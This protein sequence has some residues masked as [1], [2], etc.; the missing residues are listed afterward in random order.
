MGGE[1]GKNKNKWTQSA[2]GRQAWGLQVQK[3]GPCCIAEYLL[4]VDTGQ[5][6]ASEWLGGLW[7]TQGSDFESLVHMS[8]LVFLVPHLNLTSEYHL[9]VYRHCLSQ[10]PLLETLP[11]ILTGLLNPSRPGA[12][13]PHLVP[14]ILRFCGLL[15]LL[16]T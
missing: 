9:E 8:G 12:T 7:R 13:H 11:N 10:S 3:E 4:Q 6:H 15:L 16:G 14:L 5:V 1:G 2:L